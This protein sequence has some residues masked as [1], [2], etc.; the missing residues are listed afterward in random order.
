MLK[1]RRIS[2]VILSGKKIQ[3]ILGRTYFRIPGNCWRF[4]GRKCR[5]CAVTILDSF[6]SSHCRCLQKFPLEIPPG[7][8]TGDSSKN[9]HRGYFQE[10]P[11]VIPPRIP[12]GDFFKNSHHYLPPEIPP[13]IL[14]GNIPGISTGVPW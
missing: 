14:I 10:L 7:F 13:E 12:T 11:L 1:C 4:L 6:R 5:T 2:W 3:R 8:F 9:S